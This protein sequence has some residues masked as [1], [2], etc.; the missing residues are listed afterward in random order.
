MSEFKSTN[1]E[2]GTF[3]VSV[4]VLG[5]A[6]GPLLLA[7]MSEIIGRSPVYHVSNILFLIF[8]VACALSK[9]ISML[10]GFRFLQGCVGGTPLVIGSGS[11]S[12][13][14]APQN[15]AQAMAL[16]SLGPMLGPVIGPLAGGY[17]AD[18]V[19]WRWDFWICAI[20]VGH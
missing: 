5:Y 13:L 15:R 10:I 6:F 16:W 11:I 18:A 4:F 12:D 2:L 19:G 8:T 3:T 14:V 1:D 7:P 20:A 9:N 17:L